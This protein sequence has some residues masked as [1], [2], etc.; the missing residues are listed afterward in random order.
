MGAGK[1]IK[2]ILL[3]RSYTITALAEDM[4]IPRQTLANKISQDNL[5]INSTLKIAR[6][7]RCELVLRD[8]TS[9]KEYII[10]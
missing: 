8:R 6:E 9:G 7:L 1:A 5:T 10:E 4:E 2:H 3:D